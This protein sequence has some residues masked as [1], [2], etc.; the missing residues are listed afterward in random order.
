MANSDLAATRTLGALPGA[1][2]PNA[3]W[4][5]SAEII[6]KRLRN[7]KAE[8]QDDYRLEEVATDGH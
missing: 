6:N 1:L 5:E 7:S 4:E 3:S 2:P 8:H